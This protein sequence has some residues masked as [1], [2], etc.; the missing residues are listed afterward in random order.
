MGPPADQRRAGLFFAGHPAV[1]LP[2]WIVQAA[3][4]ILR[5]DF[6]A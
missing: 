5:L 1:T 6:G 2:P 4:G 3:L